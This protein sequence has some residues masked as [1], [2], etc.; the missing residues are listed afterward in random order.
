M[1]EN[2]GQPGDSRLTTLTE[3]R[4]LAEVRQSC[5]GTCTTRI[6]GRAGRTRER[7]RR[8]RG[9]DARPSVYISTVAALRELPGPGW[10]S[11]PDLTRCIAQSV[12]DY[13]TT[14]RHLVM[15]APDSLMVRR[16]K[17][18]DFTENGAAVWRVER[19]IK[20]RYLDRPPA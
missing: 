14:R 5:Q 6:R 13:A 8:V 1:T 2:G 18:Y 10:Y 19:F 9:E 17:G 15:D 4:G 7:L 3:H 11:E 16:E 12:H 20:E